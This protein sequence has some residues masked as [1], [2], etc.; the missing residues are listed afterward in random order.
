M[1]RLEGI[2]LTKRERGEADFVYSVYTKEAGRIL[3][4]ARGVRKITAKLRPYLDTFNH[5]ELHVVRG[6][7][8]RIITDVYLKQNYSLRF[9][10]DHFRFVQAR[11]FAEFLDEQFSGEERSSE[12]WDFISESFRALAMEDERYVRKQQK[13][14]YHLIFRLSSLLGIAPQLYRC[15]SC[16][17]KLKTGGCF[18]FRFG[19][20]GTLC[21]VCKKAGDIELDE[22]DVKLLRVFT[23]KEWGYTRRIK[24]TLDN[25][26]FLDRIS[27]QFLLSSPLS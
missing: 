14:F 7:T 26:A 22:N 23:E 15:V 13:V 2:I 1:E 19:E 24:L 17:Q 27:E 16:S 10:R 9:S 18:F 5:I 6:K 3:L 8:A 4:L 12:L 20:G 25:L 21:S 11:R